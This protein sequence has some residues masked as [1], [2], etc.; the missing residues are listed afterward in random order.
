MCAR[1]TLRADAESIQ[2]A[3]ALAS[4]ENWAGPRYNIAPTQSVAVIA[5]Q[6]PK[7]LAKMKWGF[8]P[9]W[10]KDPKIGSRMVNA[11][12]ETA[13]EKPAFRSAFRRRRCLIPA[14]GYYEWMP[15]G[16]RKTPV[17]IQHAQRDLFA[18]AGLWERWQDARGNWLHSCAI[19]T[20][21]ANQRIRPIHQRMAV[22]LE[23][24]DYALW[25]APRGLT[26]SEWQPLMAGPRDEQ[27]RYHEVSAHVNDARKD[28]P[29]LIAPAQS[30]QPRLLL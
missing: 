15:Q 20:T 4:A 8:V 10:A 19:L 16:G 14:D 24:A 2:R 13:H 28:H 11:R 30:S 26:P 27:L 6:Q 25:L 1:Y 21:A 17:Y 12:S 7:A 29:A 18:F 23:P 3:F 9:A 5:N 22:I